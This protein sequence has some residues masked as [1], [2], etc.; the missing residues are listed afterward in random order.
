MP[1]YHVRLDGTLWVSAFAV[2]EARSKREAVAT[3]RA[4]PDR[5]LTW[6]LIDEETT[7]GAAVGVTPRAQEPDQITRVS[8]VPAEQDW[9]HPDEEQTDE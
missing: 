8:V 7:D 1:T 3:A 5:P 2:V 9:Q 6:D 4:I